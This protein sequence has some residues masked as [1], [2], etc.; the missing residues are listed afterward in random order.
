MSSFNK[1]VAESLTTR[2]IVYSISEKADL[3]SLYEL[4]LQVLKMYILQIKTGK[5]FGEVKNQLC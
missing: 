4:R 5:K 3:E 1:I 2:E